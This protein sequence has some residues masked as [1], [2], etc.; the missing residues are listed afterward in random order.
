[1]TKSIKTEEV[2]QCAE[3]GSIYEFRF[4][5]EIQDEFISKFQDRFGCNKSF[6]KGESFQIFDTEYVVSHHSKCRVCDP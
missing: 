2:E 4:E 1:M 5:D 6:E 3:C